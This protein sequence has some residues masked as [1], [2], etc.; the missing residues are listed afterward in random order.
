[1]KNVVIRKFEH[2]DVDDFIRLS[3][4]SFAE[5]SIAA[6]ITP[7][8]FENETRRIF[9]WKMIPYKLLTALMGVKWEGFVAETDGKVVG[10]GMYIGRNNRMTITNL[11]VD[12]EYR[13]Q[14][15]GQALL[16]KRLERLSER[17]FPYVTA[18]VLDTNSASLANIKKQN[19]NVFNQYSVYERILPLPESK[20]STITPLTVRE[21]NRSDKALFRE[22]EKRTT[23]P[24]V[25]YVNG[26]AETRYFL[27]GWQ[28]LYVRYTGYSKWIRALVAQGETI[29]FLCADF[30]Y[31]Q[32]KGFLIQPVVADEG[33][34]YLP[35]MI[36]KVGAWLE[37]SGKES[38]IIEIPD[39][40]TQISNY[41][42]SNGWNKQYTWS[43]LIRWLDERARQKIKDL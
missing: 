33:L 13:R 6:G 28:K 5:E 21:V 32:R 8:D 30:Q 25:L 7:E 34:Q 35:A 36:Q 24:F 41:L 29:G 1:M 37:E 43:E 16:I 11:M 19:F 31:R 23:P 22:I 3:K 38:M 27:S 10:G 26:S 14:G 15:I 18:Q 39:Q 4:S 12:P 40:R 17:G 2:T 20:D 9:R 42:L